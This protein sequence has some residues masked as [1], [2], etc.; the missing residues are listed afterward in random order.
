MWG[1]NGRQVGT[2]YPEGRH[3]NQQKGNTKGDIGWVCRKKR[4]WQQQQATLTKPLCRRG[5]A[6]VQ[7]HWSPGWCS[8]ALQGFLQPDSRSTSAQRRQTHTGSIGFL[9]GLLVRVGRVCLGHACFCN[10]KVGEASQTGFGAPGLVRSLQLGGL[11]A[12]RSTDFLHVLIRSSNGLYKPFPRLST[13]KTH[14]SSAKP[15]VERVAKV[16]LFQDGPKVMQLEGVDAATV[17]A[18]ELQEALEA[19]QLHMRKGWL[20]TVCVSCYDRPVVIIEA[21]VCACCDPA[22]AP[23]Y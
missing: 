14:S 21:P 11:P 5:I 17:T 16:V 19:P 6:L 3:A 15:M 10:P 7:R 8:Q 1:D 23:R 22:L 9:E 2:G 12:A 20:C 18:D 13:F 4:K